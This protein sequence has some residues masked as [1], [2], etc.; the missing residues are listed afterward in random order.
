M[1]EREGVD[2]LADAR[3]LAGIDPR[4]SLMANVAAHSLRRFDAF[5]V[6]KIAMFAL[7]AAMLTISNWEVANQ[8]TIRRAND[9]ANRKAR[10]EQLRNGTHQAPAD[11]LV[12][13]RIGSAL[14]T[15]LASRGM[16]RPCGAKDRELFAALGLL[17]L[18]AALM[19]AVD[20]REGLL[21]D[22]A[23]CIYGW[24]H[25]KPKTKPTAPWRDSL[26]AMLPKLRGPDGVDLPAKRAHKVFLEVHPH[27][28][29]EVE[30]VSTFGV[31]LS[32]LRKEVR[33][34]QF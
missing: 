13:P 18:K 29:V 26:E 11:A 16:K 24:Q 2:L 31:A 33:D 8:D 25:L 7:D 14:W 5:S 9:P 30:N 27:F 3:H 17:L 10:H 12:I 4:F 6:Y 23:E 28:K 22:A 32:R 34:A 21:L 1:N 19:A 15:V 20:Q